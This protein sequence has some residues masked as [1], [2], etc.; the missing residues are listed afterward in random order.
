MTAHRTP[1]ACTIQCTEC[2]R[3]FATHDAR[4]Q[5]QRDKHLGGKLHDVDVEP[6]WGGSCEN[7]GESRLLS[8]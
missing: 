1:P 5:H 7:C 4:R 2:E 3:R 8:R 6:D